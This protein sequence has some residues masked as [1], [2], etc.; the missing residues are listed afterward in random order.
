[1][2]DWL[3]AAPR[4]TVAAN[5]L[6]CELSI[7]DQASRPPRSLQPDEVLDIGGKRLRLLATPHVPHGWDASLLFEEQTG[8]LL[9]G[10]LFTQAGDPPPRRD[11][12]L[13]EPAIEAEAMFS[14]TAPTPLFGPSVRRL[15]ALEPTTLACMHGSS[16][17]GDGGA[18]L[19]ALADAYEERFVPSNGPAPAPASEPG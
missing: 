15:A 16:Y 6:A 19:R 13:L 4:A 2:N 7:E 1:M 11:G 3:V 9:A 12:D 18:A 14:S 5:S 17:R 8:T 10:D